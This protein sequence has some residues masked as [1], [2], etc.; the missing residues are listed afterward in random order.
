MMENL[1]CDMNNSMRVM[2]EELK[3]E[4]NNSIRLF[5]GTVTESIEYAQKK[6][7]S[8]C[9][10]I[11][12]VESGYRELKCENDSLWKAIN[13]LR[14]ENVHLKAKMLNIESHSKKSNLLFDGFP[15]S[16]KESEDS[17]RA[18][19]NEVLTLLQLKGG[20]KRSTWEV[21]TWKK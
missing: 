13:K 8:A 21:R 3:S 16:P 14:Q 5:E 9:E 19:V 1:K 18:K 17:C 20:D 10:A 7:D 4:M 6:A 12:K 15:D 2:K 11:S